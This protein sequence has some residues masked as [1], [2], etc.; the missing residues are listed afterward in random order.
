MQDNNK[1]VISLPESRK[2]EIIVRTKK[3]LQII[4]K[5]GQIY[6]IV[7]SLTK[8]CIVYNGAFAMM[9]WARNETK[10]FGIFVYT[11]CLIN[12]CYF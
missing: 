1:K 11:S 6:A 3:L 10:N 7:R 5:K 4:H 2:L 12:L 9:N 8:S